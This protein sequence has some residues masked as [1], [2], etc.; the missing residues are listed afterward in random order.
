MFYMLTAFNL[1]DGSTMQEFESALRTMSAQLSEAGLLESTGPIGRRHRHPVM[2][3][4]MRDFEYF[5]LMTFR[6]QEQ[7]DASVE[8]MYELGAHDDPAHVAT[9]SKIGDAVFTCW[10][11][12]E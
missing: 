6:D 9:Y 12:D 1:R 3:T 8:K 2:D 4:D 10:E 5:F 7:C 11:D